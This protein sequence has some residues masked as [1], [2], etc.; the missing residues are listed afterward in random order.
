MTNG[1]AKKWR[2]FPIPRKTLEFARLIHNI[3]LFAG[4]TTPVLGPMSHF[5]EIARSDHVFVA[6]LQRFPIRKAQ[7]EPSATFLRF[8][9]RTPSPQENLGVVPQRA[10]PPTRTAPKRNAPP[11]AGGAAALR[12]R[13]SARNTE[14]PPTCVASATPRGRVGGSSGACLTRIDA[15]TTPRG[16]VGAA[17]SS[18]RA[19][20]QRPVRRSTSQRVCLTTRA[21][22]PHKQTG[23]P[24]CSERA[25]AS[26]FAT[27]RTGG[28]AASRKA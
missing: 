16:R 6:S 25:K 9:A 4:T 14:P 7:N 27:S 18:C 1:E 5:S 12:Q 22:L 8:G 20:P 11:P 21:A 3:G 26:V 19:R 23:L 13:R 28:P 2:T 10:K 15:A 24:A 17:G